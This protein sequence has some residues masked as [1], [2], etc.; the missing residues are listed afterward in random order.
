M[1]TLEQALQTALVFVMG[2]GAAAMFAKRSMRNISSDGA[3]IDIVEQLRREVK[4][5]AAQ[6]AKLGHMLNQL[7]MEMINVRMENG[8]LRM[9]LKKLGVAV[10]DIPTAPLQADEKDAPSRWFS[11]T[12]FD[13]SSPGD[14]DPPKS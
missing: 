4:R 9:L 13:A 1:I 10:E 5:L 12:G 6:N 8:E 11:D 14:F 2:G 3:Q 7:Q